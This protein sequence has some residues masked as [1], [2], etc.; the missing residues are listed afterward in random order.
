MTWSDILTAIVTSLIA[1]VVFWLV[2]NLIPNVVER[3]KIK[4]L[5]D[6]DLYQIYVKLAHFLEIPLKHSNHSPSHLQMRLYQGKLKKEDYELYLSTKCQTE[7]YQQVDDVA[8]NLMLIG[9]A[10]KSRAGE[11]VE[12]IQKLYVFNKYL[13]AKEILLCRK[14]TD[15]IT[16]Y[17]F[18]MKA[19]H[20]IGNQML[21]PVDPT[22][23]SMAG[24]FYD[25]YLLF[26]ELQNNLIGQKPSGNEL[27]D[28]H[29]NLNFR[30]MGLLYGQGKYKKVVRLT[31]GK[32]DANASGYYFRSLY[33]QR[34]TEK[35]LAALKN[36]LEKDSMKL[37]Y[38]RGTF[39]EFMDDDVIKEALIAARSEDEYQEM[40]ACIKEEQEQQRIYEEFARQMQEFYRKKLGEHV[41]K[42]VKKNNS[43]AKPLRT[44]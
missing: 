30:R 20:R 6:F 36:H 12:M 7:E 19:F 10:L 37:I 38:Q 35:A 9:A 2:F 29:R 5:L 39:V 13:S 4:P 16:T 41:G 24:M 1:S 14:I 25:A 15:K 28:F 34:K 18:E 21:G 33:R 17:D 32:R 26:L 3:K 8:K 31:K 44:G 27:G 40:V 23:R 43:P 42:G 11:I 22:M